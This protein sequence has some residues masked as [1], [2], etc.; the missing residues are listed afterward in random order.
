MAL[1]QQPAQHR[2]LDA[3]VVQRRILC[4]VNQFERKRN[5]L[6]GAACDANGQVGFDVVEQSDQLFL[7]CF[8]FRRGF[9]QYRSD[10]C[11]DGG[12]RRRLGRRSSDGG[13]DGRRRGGCEH[14]QRRAR[15]QRQQRSAGQRRRCTLFQ[16]YVL[17]VHFLSSKRCKVRNSVSWKKNFPKEKRA[18]CGFCFQ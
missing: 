15:R 10:V 3:V 11:G 18:E 2:A 16:N 6:E 1:V 5:G 9:G 14:G 7:P 13:G 12:G 8:Y 4:P 17:H